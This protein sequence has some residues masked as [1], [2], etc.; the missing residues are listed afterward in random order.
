MNF[1]ELDIFN[2]NMYIFKAPCNQKSEKNKK[3][4]KVV[5]MTTGIDSISKKDDI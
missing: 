2:F 3:G 1:V 5:L 4:W